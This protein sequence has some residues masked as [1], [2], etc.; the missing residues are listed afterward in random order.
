[1]G[2]R[3]GVRMKREMTDGASAGAAKQAGVWVQLALDF[4]AY[5]A[6][7]LVPWPDG[8]GRGAWLARKKREAEETKDTAAEDEDSKELRSEE[9]ERV[10]AM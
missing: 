4:P 10:R 6:G 3:K 1:M 9:D 8:E 2:A 7:K 5:G